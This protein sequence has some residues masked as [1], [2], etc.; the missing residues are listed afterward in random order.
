MH[1]HDED[2]GERRRSVLTDEDLRRIKEVTCTCPNGVSAETVLRMKDFLNW[3]ERLKV[4][5]GDVVIKMIIGALLA[6][7]F[8]FGYKNI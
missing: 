5:I 6:V 4:C 1:D 7:M 8:F 3:L 2:I